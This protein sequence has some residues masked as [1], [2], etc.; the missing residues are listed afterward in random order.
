MWTAFFRT[1]LRRPTVWALILLASLSE[2]AGFVQLDVSSHAYRGDNQEALLHGLAPFGLLGLGGLSGGVALSLRARCERNGVSRSGTTD[3][4][5]DACLT[6]SIVLVAGF[7]V[8][9]IL[10]AGIRVFL[11]QSS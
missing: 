2:F 7:V 11:S 4:L 10:F 9:G 6:V 8:G 1:A 5:T 3:A